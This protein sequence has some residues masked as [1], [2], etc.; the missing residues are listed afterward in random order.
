MSKQGKHSRNEQRKYS[1]KTSNNPL[2]QNDYDTDY[3][4]ANAR[5][6]SSSVSQRSFQDSF[7]RRRKRQVGYLLLLSCRL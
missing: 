1:N 7:K 4:W 3:Q 5:V 6:Q 2:K